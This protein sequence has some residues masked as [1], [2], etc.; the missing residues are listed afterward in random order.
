[1]RTEDKKQQNLIKDTKENEKDIYK[2]TLLKK[3]SPY[4]ISLSPWISKLKAKDDIYNI[5][6]AETILEMLSDK[7][8]QLHKKYFSKEYV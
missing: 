8:K 6:N 5:S 3:I 4:Y 7:D 2:F 1:M